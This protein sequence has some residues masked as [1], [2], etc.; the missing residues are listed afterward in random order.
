MFMKRIFGIFATMVMAASVAAQ[1]PTHNVDI[2]LGA[3]LQTSRLSLENGDDKPGCGWAIN[4]TYRY[5]FTDNFG[6]GAGLGL[7]FYKSKVKYDMSYTLDAEEHGDNG[8]QFEPVLDYNSWVESQRIMALEVPVAAYY[9][10]PV[11]DKWTFMGDAGVKAVL[12]VWNRFHV[13]DGA[14]EVKGYFPDT[15]ITY[16]DLPQH[17]FMEHHHSYGESDLKTIAAAG[18]ADAGMVCDFRGYKV[19][20]GA[21]FSYAFTNLVGDKDKKL[22]DGKHYAGIASSN[23]VDK[24]H[25]MSAGLKVGLTLGYPKQIAVEVEGE[26]VPTAEDETPVETEPSA[27]E[28]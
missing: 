16:E 23:V 12:P 21:F 1:V 13:N 26:E 4:G 25:L 24:A 15:H 19:Y 18:F 10:K 8:W 28:D 9:L 5:M 27:V 17:G 3:G 2:T 22:F 20:M 14:I 6:A 11:N 7:S